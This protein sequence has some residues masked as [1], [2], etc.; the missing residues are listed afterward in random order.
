MPTHMLQNFEKGYIDIRKVAR[1]D[2]EQHVPI[3]SYQG[4]N[5][6]VF[7]AN[8]GGT[9]TTLVGAAANLSTS[10]NTLRIGEKFLLFNAAGVP[11]ENTV[12]K[13]TAHNGTTTVTFT[14]AAAVATVSGDTAKIV[15]SD[16]TDSMQSMDDSLIAT[17]KYT[18]AQCDKLTA[19]DK[20][21][22]LRVETDLVG[23]RG[24]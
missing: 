1:G 14:P 23:T 8:A 3:G 10:L 16:A 4:A 11:K 6:N 22:A 21:Y 2:S 24:F 18:Q 17:G 20:V 15:A 9:T 19:N 7:T 5:P 13:V 12:F